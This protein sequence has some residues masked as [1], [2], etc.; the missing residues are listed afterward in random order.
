MSRPWKVLLVT[1]VAVFMSF[2]D[3]TIVN[4]AFPDIEKSFPDASLG[5]LSWILNAYNIVF[6]ALLVP[7][8]RVAD[9]VGRRKMFFVGLW[10]FLGASA[11]AAAAPNVE[12]LIA[13]RVLQAVGGAIVVPTSLGLMLPEFPAAKRA[14]AT[15]VWGATG[16]V[17]AATGPS[18]GGVLVDAAG[19]RW[20]FLV[21]LLIGIPAYFPARRL[22][23]ERKDPNADRALPDALGVLVLTLAVGLISLG[24]VKGPDWNWDGRVAGAIAVG[25]VLI[26]AFVLRSR[27]HASPVIELSLFRIRSFAVA[28]S[29]VFVF[30]VAFYALLLAN[31][32]FLTQVWDYSVLKA[33]FA[34][35][36]GPL[37][38]A[39]FSVVGGKLSDRYGQRVVAVPGGLTFGLGALLLSVMP[40]AE[41]HYWSH[42]F[43]AMVVTGMGVGLTFASLSSAAVAE[44]PPHS[45]STGSAVSAAFRQLGAVLGISLLVAVLGT[46]AP[47]DAVATFHHAYALM[48]I[49]GGVAGLMG[50]ALGRVRATGTE[51]VPEGAMAAA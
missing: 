45:F 30:A 35:T 43:P 32:L 47:E 50:L 9:M 14:T 15:A 16:A 4:I 34:V 26:V 1:S 28:S 39:V 8:G 27:R 21:N 3:A 12:L 36:A 46:P 29:A 5:D 24:L 33:G 23:V 13:A 2:L 44:L 37:T 19:W 25:A 40:G 49:A 6:A 11:L 7:A 17:A 10:T 18:L 31:I 41:P 42:I 51:P 48:A 38:A 22:L 20:V